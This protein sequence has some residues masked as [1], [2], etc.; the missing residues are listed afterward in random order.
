MVSVS[1]SLFTKYDFLQAS[2]KHKIFVELA[3][4]YAS[5]NRFETVQSQV[6]IKY[7]HC[8]LA[9]PSKCVFRKYRYDL[10]F[11]VDYGHDHSLDVSQRL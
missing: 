9:S 2:T 8:F 5:A 11:N 1:S 7:G 10:L 3:S 6:S 4:L